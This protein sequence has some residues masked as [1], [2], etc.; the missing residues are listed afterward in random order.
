MALKVTGTGIT[1]GVGLGPISNNYSDSK[2]RLILY[3]KSEPRDGKVVISGNISIQTY[4]DSGTYYWNDSGNSLSVS[5]NGTSLVSGQSSTINTNGTSA[6]GYTNCQTIYT[7][8]EQTISKTGTYEITATFNRGSGSTGSNLNP[9]VTQVITVEGA[10]TA[11]SNIQLINNGDNT[12]TPKA[13]LGDNSTGIHFYYYFGDGIHT[14]TESTPDV[15]SNHNGVS[16]AGADGIGQPI[17]IYNGIKKVFIRAWTIPNEQG[18]WSSQSFDVEYIQKQNTLAVEQVDKTIKVTWDS[19][20]F[21]DCHGINL[22]VKV[23]DGEV[24]EYYPTTFADNVYEFIP[25]GAK[26]NSKIS[27]TAN[28]SYEI[29]AYSDALKRMDSTG[30]N[31]VEYSQTITYKDNS[32]KVYICKDGKWVPGQMYICKNDSW[33]KAAQAKICN[34][35]SWK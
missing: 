9:T 8:P 19:D 6:H 30:P 33:K 26:D 10:Q 24:L 11:P 14:I 20:E 18:L 31:Y 4:R 7:I 5:F 17:K 1:E 15:I 16:G 23:D 13:V 29:Y 32:V 27:I 3:T 12:Y 21:F 22:A 35:S 34:N 2:F 28:F 25:E